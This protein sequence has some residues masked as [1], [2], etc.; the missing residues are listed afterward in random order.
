MLIS[1]LQK[2]RAIADYQFG[3]GIGNFLFPDNVKLSF[4]RR[5]GKIRHISLEN[6]LLATLRPTSGLF[7]LTVE[8]A[9]RMM[10][11]EPRRLWVEIQDDVSDFIAKGRTVFAKHVIDCDEEIRPGEEV[12]VISKEGRVLAVGRAV[13][14]GSEM[15]A[16]S[17]SVAVR[18][19][20]GI[21]ENRKRKVKR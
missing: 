14:A 9:G 7:A 20:R 5:T 12:A 21:S 19:R 1:P 18:V 6:E 10:L 13:L 15:K 17:H 11:F 3:R 16:F 2:I 8:G 4:S